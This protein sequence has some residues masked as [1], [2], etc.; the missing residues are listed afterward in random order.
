MYLSNFV[1][2]GHKSDVKQPR[3]GEVYELFYI[4]IRF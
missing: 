2:I 3:N 1:H 4:Q